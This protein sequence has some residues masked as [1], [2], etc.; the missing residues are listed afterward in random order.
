MPH[1]LEVHIYILVRVNALL[2]TLTPLSVDIHLHIVLL[3]NHVLIAAE[4]DHTLT[5]KTTQ[6]FNVNLLLILLNNLHQFFITLF[7]QLGTQY[8]SPK[9]LF[10]TTLLHIV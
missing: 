2:A 6:I 3:L 5:Q 8:V 7:Q 1:P 9:Y 10:F 4:V